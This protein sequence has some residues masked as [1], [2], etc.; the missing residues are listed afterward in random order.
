MDDLI[1]RLK[2]EDESVKLAAIAALG[3][4][5]GEDAKGVLSQLLASRKREM[6]DAARDAMETLL[7]E[8][9]PFRS[10]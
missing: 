3:A 5:G 6:R 2:D 8:Q 1:A 9:D 4:V 7:D 10:L